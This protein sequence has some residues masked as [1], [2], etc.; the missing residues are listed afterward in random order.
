MDGS[1]LQWSDLGRI[2]ALSAPYPY[3]AEGFHIDGHEEGNS[4]T[5]WELKNKGIALLG[6]E[7][8]TLDYTVDWDLLITRMRHNLNSYWR[9]FTREPM[10]IGW[11]LSDYGIQ[12]VVLGVLRQYYTFQEQDITSKTEAGQYGLIH[13][14][15]RWQRLID[16]AIHIR[17]QGKGCCYH[18]RILRAVEAFR[19]VRF[20]I[21]FC[22]TTF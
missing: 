14:P 4:V 15:P 13:L 6:P 21:Q 8:I 1:Y 20:M 18:S 16:E 10:R 5:W 17:E 12:W 19:F 3:Y 9:R 7:P 11:L 22:N 2:E